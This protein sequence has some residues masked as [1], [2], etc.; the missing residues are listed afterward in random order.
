MERQ[1]VMSQSTS[2]AIPAAQFATSQAAHS[3]PDCLSG[4]GKSIH[5]ILIADDSLTERTYLS[6]I[7]NAAGYQVIS[8]D[9][10]NEAFKQAQKHKPDLILLD[11]IMEN[12]DGYR[13]CRQLGRL[14]S[15]KNIPVIMVSSKSNEADQQWALQL[16]ATGYITKPYTKNDILKQISK[17]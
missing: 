15:T 1:S 11:I 2:Q 14:E 7:L 10:G 3:K 9:S 16:G 5:I 4:G 8:V 6:Q 17:L 13:T 12:G